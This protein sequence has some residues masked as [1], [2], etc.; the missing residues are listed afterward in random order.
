M[1]KYVRV[2]LLFLTGVKSFKLN[3]RPC[4]LP[5]LV[6]G[7]RLGNVALQ[8]GNL[9]VLIGQLALFLLK[10]IVRLP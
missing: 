8:A 2:S 4:L 10:L 7:A 1:A 9:F 6:V 3:Q 5:D